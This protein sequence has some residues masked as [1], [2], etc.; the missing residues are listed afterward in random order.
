MS[1]YTHIPHPHKPMNVASVHKEKLR[2]AGLNT[3][4]AVSITKLVGTMWCAYVFTV[5]AVIGLFGLLGWLNPF[6]FLLA[7]WVS[8]QFLQL[9]FLPILS[10]GQNVINQH[11]ELQSQEQFDTTMKA[12]HE[13]EQVMH[14]LDAQDA[15]ILEIV[16]RQEEQ[17]Q[18]MLASLSALK[19]G[20]RPS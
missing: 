18:E 6:T 16:E 8:Q 4:L 1:L 19:R 9:V 12:E 20:R 10:V 11:Q 14:H 15:K 5:L 17:H 7:T 13:I 3:R 2:A